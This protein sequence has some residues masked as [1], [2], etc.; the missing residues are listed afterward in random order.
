M[1]KREGELERGKARVLCVKIK[2]WCDS[3]LFAQDL[4]RKKKEEVRAKSS[5]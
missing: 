1:Q 5:K 2:D 3:S 4:A